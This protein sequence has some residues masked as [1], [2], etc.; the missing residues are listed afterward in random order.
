MKIIRETLNI[1]RG[2]KPSV[3]V[4][5]YRPDGCADRLPVLLNMH[6]GTWIGGTAELM[7]TFCEK[8]SEKLPAFVVN[9]D[10]TPVNIVRYPNPVDE[11]VCASRYFYANADAF[12]LDKTA[13]SLCGHSAGAQLAGAA[14]Y[15]LRDMG[16]RLCA[17][18]MVYPCVLI[19]SLDERTRSWL[20]PLMFPRGIEEADP[21]LILHTVDEMKGLPPAVVI[22][23]GKDELRQ[24][25][26]DY[27]YKLMN[28]SVPVS[29]IEYENALHGFVEVN[30]PDYPPDERQ[31]PEQ[32]ELCREAEDYILRSL[33]SLF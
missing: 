1:P 16:I 17:Q 3:K 7:H 30:R 20:E 12:G 31:T 29:F 14:A 2:D 9:V 4:Y 18:V 26:I 13:F 22:V 19:S 15:R 10:Y 33:H 6:G 32:A 5:T 27:A 23:C 11:I 28:A 24:Q 8:M 25:G 21:S